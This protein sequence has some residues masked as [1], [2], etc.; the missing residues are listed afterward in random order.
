MRWAPDIE[1]GNDNNQRP[2]RI[3][4]PDR[5][6]AYGTRSFHAF[7]WHFAVGALSKRI[8][9]CDVCEPSHDIVCL[10]FFAHDKRQ[11]NSYERG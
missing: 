11:H 6:N 8:G 1:L 5:D 2:I 7:Q 4:D 10:W 3:V 9:C